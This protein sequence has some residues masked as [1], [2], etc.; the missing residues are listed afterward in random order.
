[1]CDDT[2]HATVSVAHKR[3]QLNNARHKHIDC[4]TALLCNS[5]RMSIPGDVETT[6]NDTL[7]VIGGQHREARE[8]KHFSRKH[9]APRMD[10]ISEEQACSV[11]ERGKAPRSTYHLMPAIW[12]SIQLPHPARILLPISFDI[13]C[14]WLAVLRDDTLIIDSAYALR[15]RTSSTFLGS[16]VVVLY[17]GERYKKEPP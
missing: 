11:H 5:H 7:A 13:A 15:V 12:I 6:E 3:V 2:G 16:S 10:R 14:P 4:V 1:M 17:D 8:R 9:E